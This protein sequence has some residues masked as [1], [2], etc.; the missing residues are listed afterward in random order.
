MNTPIEDRSL[1]SIYLQEFMAILAMF[2]EVAIKL[3][4][5]FCLGL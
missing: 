1:V 5:T 4:H 2:L 3:T